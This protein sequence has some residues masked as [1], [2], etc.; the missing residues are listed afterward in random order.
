MSSSLSDLLYAANDKA[1]DGD[2]DVSALIAS[3]NERGGVTAESTP[4][5]E[6]EAEAEQGQAANVADLPQSES[7]EE[8]QVEESEQESEDEQP[9]EAPESV[10]DTLFAQFRQM[11]P[12]ESVARTAQR[13]TDALRDADEPEPQEQG[14]DAL[15][16][17]RSEF[18]QYASAQQEAEDAL[19]ALEKQAEESGAILDFKDVRKEYEAVQNARAERVAAYKDLQNEALAQV[20]A[21]YPELANDSPAQQIFM[22]NLKAA[23]RVNPAFDAHDPTIAA[24]M[25]R[26]AAEIARSFPQAQPE[27]KK[28]A[29]PARKVAAGPK[30]P[31]AALPSAVQAKNALVGT[32][33]NGPAKPLSIAEQVRA[34]AAEGKSLND[35][36]AEMNGGQPQAAYF[37]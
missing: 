28:T 32:H 8:Q 13:V 12:N 3:V 37:R 33:P 36:F 16:G 7:Q 26:E 2:V 18:D 35:I 19:A 14:A 22:A 25:A 20:Q 1:G 15:D 27:P 9:E 34:G 11:F 4:E 23:M 29:A 21:E 30:P 17:I 5:P 6:P 24:Q 31:A 10:E